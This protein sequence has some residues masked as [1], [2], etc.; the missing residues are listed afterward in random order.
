[1]MHRNNTGISTNRRGASE[2][3]YIASASLLKGHKHHV[4]LPVV[5]EPESRVGSNHICAAHSLRLTRL[6]QLDRTIIQNPEAQY[7]V[8]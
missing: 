8:V 7:P 2:L 5:R 4:P 6:I 3:V 1:M